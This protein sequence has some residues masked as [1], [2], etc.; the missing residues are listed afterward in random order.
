MGYYVGYQRYLM[1]AN[2]IEW[3]T[4]THLVV[5]PVNLRSNGPLDKSFDIDATHG[6]AMA[7]NLATLAKAHNVAPRL[8]IGG[9]GEHDGCEQGAE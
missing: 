8:M 3:A 6:P 2:Q 1:P 5:G 4:L 7:K 9:A